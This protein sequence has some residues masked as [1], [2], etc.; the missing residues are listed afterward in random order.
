M[1][2][3]VL[4]ADF[5]RIGLT[6]VGFEGFR[7][8]SVQRHTSVCRFK[9][10]YGASPEICAV[11]WKDLISTDIEEARVAL[12]SGALEKFFLCMYF[13]KTNATDE[14]LSFFSRVCEKPARKLV[15]MFATKLQALKAKKVRN[16]STVHIFSCVDKG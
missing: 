7:Q 6:L 10:H 3:R 2:N 4:N 16:K 11:I 9:S 5:L 15:W 14:K 13:L 8:Q 1:T 12:A